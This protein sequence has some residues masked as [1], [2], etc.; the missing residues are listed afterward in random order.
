MKISWRVGSGILL[1]GLI[2]MVGFLLR[3]VILESFVQPVALLLWTGNRLLASLDQAVYWIGLILVG[4]LVTFIRMAIHALQPIDHTMIHY[5]SGNTVMKKVDEWRTTI[6][7]TLDETDQPNH[8]RQSLLTLLKDVYTSKQPNR[9]ARE[10]YEA[11]ERGDISLPQQI[12]AFFFLNQAQNTR[13]SLFQ[14]L[15]QL[16]RLPGKWVRH[17]KKQDI[18]DYY[19]S[20]DEVISFM[21]QQVESEDDG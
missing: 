15:N 14:R 9:V 6:L 13:T 5:S 19:S 18:A 11:F 21:E 16:S 8:L 2:L 4:L 12:Q 10:I 3:S 20:I 17:W 7:L 1:V